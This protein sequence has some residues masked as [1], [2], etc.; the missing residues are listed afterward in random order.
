MVD[1]QNVHVG[2]VLRL[3]EKPYVRGTVYALTPLGQKNWFKIE[4]TSGR[5]ELVQKPELWE[6]IPNSL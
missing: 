4:L 5:C 2:L 6:I 3:I 1:I